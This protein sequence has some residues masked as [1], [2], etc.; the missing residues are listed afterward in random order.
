MLGIILCGGQSSRMGS[1]KGLMKVQDQ[2]WAQAAREKMKQLGLPVYISVNNKQ[3]EEYSALFDPADM[4]ID[5]PALDVHGPLGGVLNVH[6]HFPMQ[7][8]F[9]LA[10]DMPF[11]ELTIL[12]QLLDAYHTDNSDAA[13]VFTNDGEPEPL[14]AIYTARGLTHIRNLHHQQQLLRHSMKFMLE[15]LDTCYIPI[16]EDQKKA[17]QNFNAH[18]NLNGL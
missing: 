2:T 11:M 18:A 8:L 15:H 6:E 14:C 7:D 13:F 16:E 17:F 5:D 3:L 9:V 1:D 10:C 4:I 12:Q